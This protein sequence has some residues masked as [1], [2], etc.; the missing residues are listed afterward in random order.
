MDGNLRPDRSVQT[1]V[2]GLRTHVG[3][4]TVLMAEALATVGHT[5]PLGVWTEHDGLDFVD[6][7]TLMKRGQ[8]LLRRSK[9]PV[10]CLARIREKMLGFLLF[11]SADVGGDLVL[12]NVERAS[13]GEVMTPTS[14]PVLTNSEKIV[15]KKER[16]SLV[17]RKGIG[18]MWCL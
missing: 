7:T 12:K 11:E 3:D 8:D 16:K 13:I 10:R 6:S 5:A 18:I 1:V 17:L 14:M 4:Q 9:D 15:S 2:G